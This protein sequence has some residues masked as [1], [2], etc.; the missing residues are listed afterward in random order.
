MDRDR[1]RTNTWIQKGLAD[2]SQIVALEGAQ[3]YQTTVKSGVPQGPV[4]GPCVFLFY[5]NGLLD[6]L[7][8][9]VRLFANDTVVYLSVVQ[10]QDASILQ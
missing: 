7:R 1:E 4:V 8:S 5:I 2:R 9:E 6:T 10:Q 3:S